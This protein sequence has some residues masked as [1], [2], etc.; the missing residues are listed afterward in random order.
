M[1]RI[2]TRAAQCTVHS[3]TRLRS[4]ASSA[5]ILNHGQLRHSQP[6]MMIYDINGR[7]TE[8][9]FHRDNSV[10]FSAMSTRKVVVDGQEM[11]VFEGDVACRLHTLVS[12]YRT[13]GHLE[14][15]LDCLNLRSP[16]K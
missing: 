14:A 10:S 15:D 12:A 9:H 2:I 6:T 3:A 11:R 4:H 8:R 16:A 1:R 7:H 13:H 5:A